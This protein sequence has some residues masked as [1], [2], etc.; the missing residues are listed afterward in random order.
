MAAEG[1]Y[2][3]VEDIFSDHHRL[4]TFEETW[5][6]AIKSL[7]GVQNQTNNSQRD[8]ILL[9]TLTG[10]KCGNRMRICKLKLGACSGQRKTSPVA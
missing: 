9:C 10:V 7:E 1:L 6:A 4:P 2:D 5:E 8:E 3:F